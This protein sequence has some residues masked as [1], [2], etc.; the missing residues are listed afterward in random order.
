MADYNLK[1]DLLGFGRSQLKYMLFHNTTLAD[2]TA[3]TYKK[4]LFFYDTDNNS[5]E[6]IHDPTSDWR[7][8]LNII[9]KNNP[10]YDVN[11][12][13]TN[14]LLIGSTAYGSVEGYNPITG[15]FVTVD[16]DGLPSTQQYVR[17]E[18][19]E[20]TDYTTVITAPGVDTRFATEKAIVDYVAAV[21]FSAQDN[22]L[23]WDGT[24][25]LPFATKKG[26]DPGYPYFYTNN[27]ITSPSFSSNNLLL[28]GTMYASAFKA[29]SG[30][31]TSVK[32]IN[33]AA[34]VLTM[35]ATVVGNSYA[36][37]MDIVSGTYR[38]YSQNAAGNCL[39]IQ[40]GSASVWPIQNDEY[41]TID[42]AN[43]LFN[44]NMTTVR[45][46]K[47]TALKYLYLDASKNITYVDAPSGSNPISVTD[48]IFNLDLTGDV[49][50][51]SA[52]SS[53]SPGVFYNTNIL[54][55][56][57]DPPTSALNVLNYNGA[58]R[59]TLLYEGD[60]R[61]MT[62]HGEQLSDG[63][64]H[65]LSNQFNAGFMPALPSENGDTKFLRG[66]GTWQVITSGGTTNPLSVSDGIFNLNITSDILT[67]TPYTSKTASA[68]YSGSDVP[69]LVSYY[70]NL[71]GIFRASQLYEGSTRVM[72]T[73]GAWAANGSLHAIT[74]ISH[75]GFCPQLTGSTSA[76]L[77]AD[78]TWAS[79]SF[80]ETDTLQTV[81]SR[82]AISS[83]I[84]AYNESKIFTN[85]YSLVTKEYVDA[86][87]SGTTPKLPVDVATTA[88]ITLSGSQTIDGYSATA[89]KRVLVKN[90]STQ[91]TNG[92]YTVASGAWTRET[93]SD[94]W[95]ELYKGYYV[96][97]NGTVNGGSSYVCSIGIT[98]TVGVNAITFSLYSTPINIV[99]GDGL[100]RVS[101]TLNVNVDDAT[102]EIIS[103]T[104]KVKD[105]VF[106]PYDLDLVSI[107]GLT[108]TVGV[109]KKTAANTW[110]LDTTSYITGDV[111]TSFNTRTG[112][113]TLTKLDVESVLTGLIT[114]HTHN[115]LPL[116]GGTI[117]G[118]LVINGTTTLNSVTK[119]GTTMIPNFNADLLDGYHASAFSLYH[120]HPY[121]PLIG[122][123]ITGNLIVNGTTTLNNIT[124]IGTSLITNLNADYLDG[125]HASAFAL[126]SHTHPYQPLNGNLTSISPL[127]GFGLLRR[128]GSDNAWYLDT[129]TYLTGTKV[130]SFNGRTGIVTLTKADVEAVLTGIITSHTHNYDNY[131]AWQFQN[132]SNSF[133]VTASNWL[134]IDTVI[135]SGITLNW[136]STY[137]RL[138][139]INNAKFP[140]FGVTH[141]K[142]AYG[143]HTHNIY[144]P[145]T[146]GTMTGALVAAANSSGTVAQVANVRYG[147]SGTLPSGTPNGTI[148]IRY[149]A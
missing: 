147:T 45:L 129:N 9:S 38:I 63:S 30:S 72:T 111:V 93:D 48:G 103:D 44:I 148:Y 104:L 35:Y 66:D 8:T 96:V 101:N 55:I 98:G 61:V 86:I 135:D 11:I 62:E 144:L 112:A 25:Y 79:A 29:Q 68:L 89:G 102:I 92:I 54:N 46:N 143:D 83:I 78:G 12:D 26:A 14:R 133:D 134:K 43:Q 67:V 114:S 84:L 140:G 34:N 145:F 118:N 49:L 21:T 23:D 115:Y 123:T 59:T 97:L 5:L 130:D 42:D 47:G 91:T 87:A 22:I 117:T 126:A 146:G 6:V 2:L 124:K 76:Y 64:F 3:Y 73:H 127:T 90:Q 142:A 32:Q 20:P 149:T 131:V 70:L 121:L 51:V 50:T 119:V 138:D 113:V 125:Y 80:T 58:F 120:E 60:K 52:F 37:V 108:G 56:T 74:N 7:T 136:N 1:D 75:A 128:D 139:I 71:D 81:A 77:R 109:L 31:G 82:G 141:T 57:S 24:K 107:A 94:T 40:I 88:N 10:L 53:A 106:Q 13:P 16:A 15:G 17:F 85:P 137:H 33:V 132:G 39:P 69:T 99:A 110:V 65:T 19:I 41:I 100:S 28:D 122:G 27:G 4:G 36:G 116:S 95:E 18:D 105:N